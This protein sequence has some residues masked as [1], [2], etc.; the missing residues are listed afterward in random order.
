MHQ[1]YIE[2]VIQTD[3]EE[4]LARE[5]G[6]VWDPDTIN[7]WRVRGYSAVAGCRQ[8]LPARYKQALDA[9]E[10]KLKHKRTPADWNSSISWT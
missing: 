5:N 3:D 6:A 4:E 8:L 10:N 1:S 9:W 7:T 2:L